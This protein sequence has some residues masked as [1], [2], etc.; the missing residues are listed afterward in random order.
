MELTDVLFGMALLQP[1]N[2]NKLLTKV[3]MPSQFV[4]LIPGLDTTSGASSARLSTAF[5]SRT[6]S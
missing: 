3:E 2:P 4:W 1:Q 5:C 6:L